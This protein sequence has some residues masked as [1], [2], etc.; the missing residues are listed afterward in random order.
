MNSVESFLTASE[1]QEIVRAIQKAE[2]N[3]SG[4]IRVHLEKVTSKEVM[5]RAKEVFF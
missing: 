1:E 2:F 5:E 3:T 4:E